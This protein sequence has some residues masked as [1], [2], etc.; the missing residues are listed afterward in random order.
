MLKF[1]SF[2]K[3]TNDKFTDYEYAIAELEKNTTIAVSEN[4]VVP[5][6]ILNENESEI[7]NNTIISVDL[8]NIIKE[9]FANE[10]I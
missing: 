10:S 1:D 3:D 6:K 4:I 2:I 5:E 9:E 7:D 8:K